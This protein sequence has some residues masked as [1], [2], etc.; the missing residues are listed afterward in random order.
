VR[1][2][3]VPYHLD[4]YQPD[5][6]IPLRPA[7]VVTA[8]LPS[9]DVW[10]RLAALY[11]VVGQAVAAAAGHAALPVVVSGDCT[12]SLGTVAGLQ[13]AGADP[14]IIWLDAHG[15]VQTLETTASGYL[16]GLPL[17]LLTGYRPELIASRLGLRPVAEQRILL[18]GARDI[19]PPEVTYL[20]SALIRRGEVTGLDAAD[21]PDGPL[22]VH[23]D[24]D[25]VDPAEVPGLRYPTP[26]GPSSAQVAGALHTLLGTGRVAA[27]GIACTWHPG[28][29]AAAHIS[30]RRAAAHAALCALHLARSTLGRAESGRSRGARST[31]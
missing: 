28:H 14:G 13:R 22:Y 29:S 19:D 4:E 6:D 15:D 30:R 20:A 17:R 10:E 31:S 21:L 16:G 25:V 24:L 18:A 11:S 9:G 7:E 12:T 23:V 2:I 27:V 1:V 3:K 5:L 8:D 26:H